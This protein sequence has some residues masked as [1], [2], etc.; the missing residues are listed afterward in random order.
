MSCLS[1]PSLVPH[2]SSKKSLPTNGTNSLPLSLFTLTPLS[3]LPLSLYRSKKRKE[4]KREENEEG[5]K[6]KKLKLSPWLYW[7]RKWSS[8]PLISLS[9]MCMPKKFPNSIFMDKFPL[10]LCSLLVKEMK[11]MIITHISRVS[12]NL[13]SIYNLCACG[14]KEPSPQLHLSQAK[15][16][17]SHWCKDFIQAWAWWRPKVTNSSRL[18]LSISFLSLEFLSPN[19][20]FGNS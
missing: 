8:P 17:P 2:V 15:E 14:C 10:I 5:R 7:R 16:L 19:H 18:S 1:P 20:G 12:S 4:T 6:E 13:N 9:H 11:T 3:S